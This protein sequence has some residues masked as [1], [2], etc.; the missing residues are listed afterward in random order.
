M[1]LIDRRKNALCRERPRFRLEN[2]IV[3]I[4]GFTCAYRSERHRL[5]IGSVRTVLGVTDAKIQK[6]NIVLQMRLGT[7][8]P[9]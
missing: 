7:G 6:S 2:R 9:A 8:R 3:T 1:S 4:S 5:K